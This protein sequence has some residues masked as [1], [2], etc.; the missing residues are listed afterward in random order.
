MFRSKR[1]ELDRSD[2]SETAISYVGIVP[3]ADVKASASQFKKAIFSCLS[4]YT[5]EDEEDINNFIRDW[6]KGSL[7]ARYIGML[8]TD[9]EFRKIRNHPKLSVVREEGCSCGDWLT[10]SC[11]LPLPRHESPNW[12]DSLCVYQVS[13]TLTEDQLEIPKVRSW[14]TSKKYTNN[15]LVHVQVSPL[16]KISAS[17]KKLFKFLKELYPDAD[18][19]R[20]ISAAEDLYK[21]SIPTFIGHYCSDHHKKVLKK[22]QKKFGVSVQHYHSWRDT[23]FDKRNPIHV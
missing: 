20:L 23:E 4:E 5:C 17:P 9:E 15:R 19:H 8:I 6:E 12:R 21:E 7:K 13:Q 2:L 18:K 14:F 1:K 16:S 22:Y 3:A 10:S 11:C